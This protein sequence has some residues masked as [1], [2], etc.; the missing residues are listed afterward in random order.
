MYLELEKVNKVIDGHKVLKDITYSFEKGRIYGI[1]GKNG[2][3]KTMLMKAICGLNSIQSGSICIDGKKLGRGNEF[4]ASVGAL[5]ENPGFINQYSGLE[6]LK[7]LAEIRG[8][9]NEE[10]IRDYMLRL[11]LNPDD[12]KSYKKYSLG[13]KQK[14]GIICAIMEHPQMI[15][16]DEP[17]NALD[18][19]SVQVLNEIIFD[20]KN[21]GALIIV[22]SHDKMELENIADEIVYMRA[23][24]IIRN[25]LDVN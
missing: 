6:N 20:R 25:F 10:R 8:E 22:A 21:A 13:M 9:A 15:I 3:G 11:S 23:G 17:T 1:C 4:P 19:E 5:I 7:I 24:E 12:R 16:L 14:I 2:C 18:E